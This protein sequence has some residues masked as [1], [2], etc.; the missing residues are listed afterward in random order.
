MHP[1]KPKG[2]ALG[3]GFH[4][5]EHLGLLQVELFNVKNDF[6]LVFGMDLSIHF[7]NKKKKLKTGT[8]IHNQKQKNCFFILYNSICKRPKSKY[9]KY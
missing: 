7:K 2:L 6:F 5:F 1:K 9:S 3:F 4:F 8:Q